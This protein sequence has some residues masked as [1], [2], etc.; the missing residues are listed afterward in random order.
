MNNIENMNDTENIENSLKQKIR[1]QITKSENIRFISHLEYA[2]TLERA[3]RRSN[4]P[5][6]YSRGFNPH[7]RFSIASALGVS[8]RSNAEFTELELEP[9]AKIDLEETMIKLDNNLPEGIKVVKADI[10]T[11]NTRKLMADAGGADYSVIVP[12]EEFDLAKQIEAYNNAET[13]LFKK[14]KPKSKGRLFKELDAKLFVPSIKGE[15]LSANE[16][17]LE[18]SVKISVL[19][20]MKSTELIAVLKKDFG[21]K[22]ELEKADILR[23]DLYLIDEDGNKKPLIEAQYVAK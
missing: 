14:L 15:K 18:F 13:A 5:I 6:A 1:I 16:V 7:M 10:V 8:I 4:L 3:I 11:K 20:S 9:N 17:K 22:I 2:R 23:E 21:F 12:C 19:G